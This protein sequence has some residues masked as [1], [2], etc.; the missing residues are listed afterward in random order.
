MGLVLWS[1]VEWMPECLQMMK[2]EEAFPYE[3]MMKRGNQEQGHG[4]ITIKIDH[5]Y[6][7]KS[8]YL[9]SAVSTPPIARVS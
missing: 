4:W 7:T 3:S 6:F 9:I 2:V 1:G 8:K 5:S